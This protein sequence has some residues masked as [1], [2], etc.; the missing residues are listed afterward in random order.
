M[1]DGRHTGTGGGNHF[2]LGGATPADSPFLRRPELLGSLVAYW[3]NHP[4]LSYL[5]SGLFV[6]PT[7]QAPRID[8]ARNDS[9]YEVEIAYL[10]GLGAESP[11]RG[12]GLVSTGDFAVDET[13]VLGVRVIVPEFPAIEIKQGEAGHTGTRTV[14]HTATRDG[15]TITGGTWAISGV[16]GGT[17]TINSSTGTVS[18]SSVTTSGEYTVA[19]THTDGVITAARVN[20]TYLPNLGVGGS[21]ALRVENSDGAISTDFWV[22]IISGD[23]TDAPAGL[24]GP[25]LCSFVPGAATGDVLGATKFQLRL[26]RGTD[27]LFTTDEF[28]GVEA[29]GTITSQWAVAAAQ[30]NRFVGSVA[31]GTATY[32]VQGRRT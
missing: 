19:Y 12:L 15:A 21:R 32:S 28:D 23:L 31:A 11:W 27:V 8:E 24:V 29:S 9:V 18:L 7:S 5:F 2:V 30:L 20:I 26:R 4:A 14:T 16:V 1:T 13:V 22:N 6:G 17:G 3:H 10:S 25:S